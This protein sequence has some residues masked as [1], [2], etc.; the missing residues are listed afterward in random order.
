MKWLFVLILVGISV[1]GCKSQ[2][3][4]T[5][6]F[7]GRTTIPPPPTGTVNG[8]PNDPC[9]Q[10]PPLVQTPA[11][12]STCPPS[13]QIPSQPSGQS[14]NIQPA[15]Q[16]MAAPPA[17]AAPVYSTPNYSAP[18]PATTGPANIYAPRPTSTAP[19]TGTVNPSVSPGP[20]PYA[21]PGGANNYRGTPS[22]GS[23]PSVSTQPSARAAAPLYTNVSA[24]GT[25]T[26]GNNRMPGPVD[27]AAA[28]GSLAGRNPIIHTI[29]PR[30]GNEVSNR[31][32]DIAD[33]PKAP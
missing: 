25:G 22:Q 28:A 8:R 13:V 23:T 21:P 16:T 11:A 24:S 10:P 15:P 9:Y 29:Q 18:R 12:S 7:F 2:A 3:P 27:D 19:A 17:S 5:D 6:P 14:S 1:T 26:A 4:V 31:A 32:V 20:S 30:T 33:L